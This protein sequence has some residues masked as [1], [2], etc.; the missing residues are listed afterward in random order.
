MNVSGVVILYYPDEKA[1]INNIGSYIDYVERLIVF[2]NSNSRSEFVETVKSISS[3]ILFISNVDNEGIAKPLN[4]ALEFIAG[5]SAGLLTMDQDSF[6][7]PE[8]ASRYF[9]SFDKLFSASEEVAVV[10]PNHSVPKGTKKVDSNYTEVTRAITSGSIINT[11]VCRKLN[12]FDEKLF[13][14]DVDLEYCYRCIL[15][16]Y[17]IMQFD[18]IYLNHSLGTSKRT[19]YFL[20]FRKS[21]RTVHSP[22]R[23]YY[24]VRNFLYVAA[25]YENSLP[26]EIRQRRRELFVILK[27]NLLFSGKFIQ[28]FVSIIKGYL[29][30]KLNKFSSD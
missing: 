16:G 2:D 23:V 7:D 4:K 3:K 14:D 22:T 8:N 25:R 24:M 13:I 20:I 1:I 28:V 17:K 10:C 18:N 9:D 11:A 21:V 19:G 12:G 26:A 30:F 5:K 27:N 15:A 29:H 6:F